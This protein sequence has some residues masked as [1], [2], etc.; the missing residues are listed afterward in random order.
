MLGFDLGQELR[1]NVT[2]QHFS[3]EFSLDR[4]SVS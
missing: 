3:F 4:I 2:A 1:Q